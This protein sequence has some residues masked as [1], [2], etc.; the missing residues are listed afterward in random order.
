VTL[1][2]TTVSVIVCAYT[3]DRWDDLVSS[4]ESVRGLP[5][6]PEV[7]LV[8]D[9]NEALLARS[10]QR[11]AD[12]VVAPNEFRQGLS[13]ARN[14]GVRLATGDVVAFLDDDASAD[15]SWL[16]HLLG[17]FADADVAGVG[18]HATPVWPD[19]GNT[20]YPPELLW[21]VGCS[22][23]GLPTGLS[24]VRNVIGCSMAFRRESILGVGGFNLDTGRVGAIPLGG[25]ETDLCIRIRQADPTARILLEPRAD[26]RHHV[27]ANRVT[28]AYLRRRSFYE[29]VSKAALSRQLGASDSLSSESAYLRRDIPRAVLRELRSVGRGGAGRLLALVTAVV[30][31]VAGY[32]LG[33]VR[34]ASL[35]PVDPVAGRAL[36]TRDSTHP[37]TAG[38]TDGTS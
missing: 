36:L 32:A 19:G 15:P 29:G 17:P 2:S 12:V 14:T 5:E 20:L 21:I 3:E 24:A 23:R 13:G 33:S 35:A 38:R 28:W 26:V 7:V 18:G 11:W 9:H 30:A 6:G 10:R 4:V 27:T 8:I 22:H 34:R 31:T 16:T 37:A 1:Q 25:E